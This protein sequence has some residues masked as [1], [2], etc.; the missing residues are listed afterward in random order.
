MK[1][2]KGSEEKEAVFYMKE[3]IKEAKKAT[4]LISKCGAVIVKSKRIIGKGY[5]SPPKNNEEQR[6]CKCDK[7]VLHAKIT[8]KTCCVHAEQRAIMNALA[9]NPSRL[10]LSRIYFIRLDLNNNVLMAGKPY[11]THCSKLALDVG[12]SE[13]VLWHKEGICV[14]DTL[15]YNILSYQFKG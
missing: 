10:P 6:R 5:N 7:A 4:C 13:F 3:A 14:Y 15:E 8:D 1:F 11:C 9:R 12:I 2:L